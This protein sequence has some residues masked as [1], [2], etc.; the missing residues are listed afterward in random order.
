[1]KWLFVYTTVGNIRIAV[2]K[3]LSVIFQEI[4]KHRYMEL[5]TP[6]KEMDIRVPVLPIYKKLPPYSVIGILRG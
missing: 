5:V 4:K 1:M 2:K 3:F 6:L